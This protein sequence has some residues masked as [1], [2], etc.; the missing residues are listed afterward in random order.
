MMDDFSMNS[1]QF[2]RNK[3]MSKIMQLDLL[4]DEHVMADVR[5]LML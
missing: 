2:G 5:L 4:K 3:L 1:L